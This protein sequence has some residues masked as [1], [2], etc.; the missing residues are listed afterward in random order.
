MAV[1]WPRIS[2]S[3]PARPAR[4]ACADSRLAQKTVF[5]HIT[6]KDPQS[7]PQFVARPA[8]TTAPG[9]LHVQVPRQTDTTTGVPSRGS[10]VV[11]C[12]G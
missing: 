4:E 11:I 2:P 1:S 6:S 5:G 7:L 9:G 3:R 12:P 10:A 8:T